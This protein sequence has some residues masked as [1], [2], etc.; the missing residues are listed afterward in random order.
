MWYLFGDFNIVRKPSDKKEFNTVS[1]AKIEINRFNEFIENIQLYEIL[2][3]GR[4]HICGIYFKQYNQKQVGQDSYHVNG[5]NPIV[6][7]E[8]VKLLKSDLKQ[9]NRAISGILN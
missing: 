5:N 8:K 7:K 9:W 1:S 4:R 6:I 2:L 3:I